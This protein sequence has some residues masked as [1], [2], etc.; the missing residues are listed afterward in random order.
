LTWNSLKNANGA[1]L[2]PTT[3]VHVGDVQAI[4][5]DRIL[6]HRRTGEGQAAERRVAFTTPGA[7]SATADRSC[8]TGRREIS[9]R[10]MLKE[11]SVD[12]TSTH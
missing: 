8:A 4:D 1:V 3:G 9:S 6:G 2:K 7:I 5:E 11:D 10:L 12:F